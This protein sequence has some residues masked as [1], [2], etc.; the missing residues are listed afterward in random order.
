MLAVA[1][2]EH[3]HP[4][5]RYLRGTAER[6]PLPDGSCD[7]ALMSQVVQH[8]EDLPAAARELRRVLRPG[9]HVIVR[10]TLRESVPGIPLFEFF[11][12]TVAI[13][14][15]DFPS[16]DE[17]SAV[18][19]RE[20]F[21]EIAREAVRQQTTASVREWYERVR[22]RAISTLEQLDDV[23]FEAG[24]ERLR[25]AAEGETAPQPVVERIDL[26]VLQRR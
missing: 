1:K 23:A 14:E 5:V 25:R 2:R 22:H 15:R 11:P 20:G 24:L 16:G 17:L 4:S 21:E 3:A 26:L 19:A 7:A 8:V 6:I 10:G 9:G 18:F 13:V 12:E